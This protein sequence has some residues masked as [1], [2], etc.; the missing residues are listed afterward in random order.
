MK[1]G[2]SMSK[3]ELEIRVDKAVAD[4]EVHSHAIRCLEAAREGK[5]GMHMFDYQRH[6]YCTGEFYCPM[7]EDRGKGFPYCERQQYARDVAG[8]NKLH[9]KDE[10][11][12]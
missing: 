2:K 1:W 7:S 9:W 3:T 12:P 5:A 10:H 11:H 4:G 8:R 6:K